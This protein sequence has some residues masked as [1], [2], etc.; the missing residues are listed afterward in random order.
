MT[1]DELTKAVAKK[2]KQVLKHQSDL[3]ALL[4]QC[5]HDEFLLAESYMEGGY[6][7][8]ATLTTWN[9]CCLC[10]EHMDKKVKTVGGYS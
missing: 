8:C 2:R 6:D 3:N 5:T 4:S 7:Y 10:G 9:Q 1:V